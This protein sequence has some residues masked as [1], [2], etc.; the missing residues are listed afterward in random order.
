MD[1]RSA[2]S[3]SAKLTRW[4]K[5][6]EEGIR[7]P[8][9]V[10]GELSFVGRAGKLSVLITLSVGIAGDVAGRSGAAVGSRSNPAQPESNK[11]KVNVSKRFLIKHLTYTYFTQR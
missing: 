9:G 8:V 4:S 10:I 6:S 2:R 3:C 1:K 7:V 11:S 5:N